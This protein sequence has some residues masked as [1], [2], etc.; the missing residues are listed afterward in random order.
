MGLFIDNV[1]NIPLSAPEEQILKD[2]FAKFTRLVISGEF[3]GGFGGA[4][5]LQVIPVP[6]AKQPV[7]VK[8][9]PKDTIDREW[10]AFDKTLKGT[11][12]NTLGVQ[13]EP[14]SIDNLGGLSYPLSGSGVFKVVRLEEYFKTRSLDDIRYTLDRLMK[15]LESMV[16]HNEV[17]GQH[18]MRLCYD[19]LLPLNLLI[20]QES[21]PPGVTS[22]VIDPN[23]PDTSLRPDTYVRVEGFQVVK[24]DHKNQNVTLNVSK[25]Q[26]ENEDKPANTYQIRI[27]PVDTQLVPGYGKV[28]PPIEG[29]I[30]RT[31]AIHFQREIETAFDQSI[32]LTGPQVTLLDGTILHNPLEQLSHY[33]ND[34]RYNIKWAKIHGDM[35]L[36]NVLVD[37]DTGDVNIIDYSEARADYALHDFL[38]L[39]TDVVL[40]ILLDVIDQPSIDLEVSTIKTFYQQ[41]HWVTFYAGAAQLKENPREENLVKP[42]EILRI[43]RKSAQRYL[44]NFEDYNE[45]YNGLIIYLLSTLKF[46]ERIKI[47]KRGA[48]IAAATLTGLIK[49][50]LGE[51]LPPSPYRGLQVFDVEHAPYFFGREEVTTTLLKKLREMINPDRGQRSQR[52]LTVR[53]LALIG[54]SGSGKS[55]LARAGIIGSLRQGRI[56]GSEHW[57]VII[58][59]PGDNVLESLQRSFKSH[60]RFSKVDRP[61]SDFIDDERTLHFI[62]EE[63]LAQTPVSHQVL[64]FIDQFEEVFSLETDVERRHAFLANLF[65]AAQI[66][67]GRTIILFTLRGDFYDR[68][69]TYEAFAQALPDHHMIVSPLNE[70]QLRHAIERPA[71][72]A[73]CVFEDGLVEKMVQ[74]VFDQPGSLPLL[75]HALMLLWDTQLRQQDAYKTRREKYQPQNKR[76]ITREAYDKIGGWAGALEKQAN[77]VY[78]NLPDSQQALCRHIFLKLVRTGEGNEFNKRPARLQE[79]LNLGDTPDEVWAVTQALADEKSRLLTVINPRGEINPKNGIA[80]SSEIWVEMAHEALIK[81]WFRLKMWIEENREAILIRDKLIEAAETWGNNEKDEAYL[82]R[83]VQLAKTE[84]WADKLNINI[85]VQEQGF[86]DASIAERERAA[87]EERERLQREIEQRQT[88]LEQERDLKEEQRQRA[89]SEHHRAEAQTK[90]KNWA[91]V[92]LAIAVVLTVLAVVSGV[93]IWVQS[94]REMSLRLA[95][96]AIANLEVDPERSILLA[97]HAITTSRTPEAEQAL[98]RAVQASRIRLTLTG[99]ADTI[100][101]VT[102]SP[103]GKRLATASYDGTAKVWDVLSG[104]A[105]LTLTGH[106]NQVWG[107]A[108]SPDGTY[109]ATTSVDKTIKLWNTATAEEVLTLSGH[110][111]TVWDV[112]F[113]PDGNY[114]ASTSFDNTTKVWDISTALDKGASTDQELLT[115]MGHHDTV[116]SVDFSPDG[117]YLATASWDGSVKIW[118]FPSGNLLHSLEH[119]SRVNCV[120]FSPDGQRLVSTSQDGKV[121][122]WN[123][124]TG[125]EFS[126]PLIKEDSEVHAVSFSPDGTRLAWVNAEGTAK[127]GNAETGQILLV[128]AGHTDAIKAVAFSPDGTRLVTAGW[129]GQIKV[130]D[131]ASHS[132][133]INHVAFSRDGT[134]LATASQDHTAKIWDVESGELLL[135]LTGHKA[136]IRRVAFNEDGTRLATASQDN[137]ARIW[138]TLSGQNILTLTGHSDWVYGV[139]FSPDG[140]RLATASYDET[141]KIWDAV[142]GEEILTLTGHDHWV[143][144]VAFS[145]DGAYLAT[146]SF[147]ETVRVW[148][149]I[150][151][152]ELFELE[153]PDTVSSV[154]FSPDGAYLATAGVEGLAKIWDVTTGEEIRNLSGHTKWVREITFDA[155]GNRIA[156]ASWDNTARVWEATSD[157]LLNTFEHASDVNSV[158]LNP[159]GLRLAT[160]SVESFPRVYLLNFE[161]LWNLSATR[162]T[163]STLSQEECLQYF[164]TS[165]CPLVP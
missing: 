69:A 157:K 86:L 125:E 145:P 6:G 64:V 40:K 36:G 132:D 58:C 139:A 103:E 24:S 134:R 88:L 127:E 29:R 89:E 12:P 38:R 120:T 41:L 54:A 44:Y 137:T 94:K 161:E 48:F 70:K 141:A 130:W 163:R 151:G 45:Y 117:E 100:W 107:V 118:Q 153:H 65:Y 85:G 11:L 74:G 47:T 56:E 131:A 34:E 109:L 112:A 128:F 140:T 42:F 143:N 18:D 5:V 90:A 43:I 9:G 154:A 14:I 82:F 15:V 17:R 95:E 20:A 133:I 13:G 87:R 115:L 1:K 165:E 110:T 2:M 16:R 101:D 162:L 19:L 68:F 37:V 80:T 138:E 79:L 71:G 21:P 3:S 23:T 73:G 75:Q 144:D 72:Q 164:N 156:T 25:V 46:K 136:M 146:A 10:Q 124:A 84:E 92:A 57:P 4:R 148:N 104:Q 97:R 116:T 30:V 8:L 113:S 59:R 152:A 33:L 27:Q 60:P 126:L 129:D 142:T 28:M 111:K 53:L 52:N 61:I 62:I 78:S 31:R 76:L 91:L 149:A 99:H 32:D 55:S 39:E 150:T 63:V 22:L 105:V 159:N 122:S 106:T 108:F 96:A 119:G 93:M 7:V 155:N 147:D 50:E 35:N 67:R 51:W 49:N 81:H 160:A 158:S 123:V 98:Q 102:F 114:L 66:E 77:T 135:T 26:E 83:G 121:R